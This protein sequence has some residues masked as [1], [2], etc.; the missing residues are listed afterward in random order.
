MRLS[1]RTLDD[2][3]PV[4]QPI[5]DDTF[6]IV[7]NPHTE[8]VKFYMPEGSLGAS[9]EECVETACPGREERR[10]FRAGEPYELAPRSL[11][12]LREREPKN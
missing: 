12:L 6:L 4:G 10:V 1:G 3:N 5:V 8:P 7:T 9:W 2:V 11:A